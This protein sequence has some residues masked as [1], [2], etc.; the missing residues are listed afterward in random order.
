VQRVFG[1][2]QRGTQ[3]EQDAR[4]EIG[5]TWARLSHGAA[6]ASVRGEQ[7]GEQLGSLPPVALALGDDLGELD[8]PRDRDVLQHSDSR[9][10]LAERLDDQ[11]GKRIAGHGDRERAHVAVGA[12]V[13]AEPEQ[14]GNGVAV[15]GDAPREHEAERHH[16]LVV[17]HRRPRLGIDQVQPEAEPPAERVEGGR[18]EV[19]GREREPQQVVE[20][21]DVAEL[22]RGVLVVRLRH[23]PDDVAEPDRVRDGE[24]RHP[25]LA[26]PRGELGRHRRA[27]RAQ[28]DHQPARPDPCEP[29]G[30]VDLRTGRR[31][32]AC[33]VGE[34]QLARP[35]VIPRLWQVRRVRPGDLVVQ[36]RRASDQSE[37]QPWPVEQAADGHGHGSPTPTS[38]LR[39]ARHTTL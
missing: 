28:A 27:A 7:L 29:L 18:P 26:D 22:L 12:A 10:P 38:P 24:Q 21:G 33:S 16:L 23:R 19:T 13:P 35:E 34:Q 17:E 25:E 1:A 11:R 31:A 14:P 2:G 37:L 30:E 6:P 5:T 8:G 9:Q 36:P 32:D 39:H 4:G 3:H 20:L 15:L